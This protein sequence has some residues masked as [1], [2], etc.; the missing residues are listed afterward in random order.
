MLLKLSMLVVAQPWP[1]LIN[2]KH[3]SLVTGNAPVVI[4]LIF[5][6]A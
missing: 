2:V 5:F 4:F 1:S 3:V 6:L